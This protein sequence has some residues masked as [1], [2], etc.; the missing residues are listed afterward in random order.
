[1]EVKP[2]YVVTL[3]SE[4]GNTLQKIEFNYYNKQEIARAVLLMLPALRTAP[5]GTELEYW[6]QD[7]KYFYITM[8]TLEKRQTGISRQLVKGSKVFYT[9][10]DEE[11]FKKLNGI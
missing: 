7:K 6:K 3:Q 10:F 2:R 9:A 4:E 1:M 5:I 8:L 11:N